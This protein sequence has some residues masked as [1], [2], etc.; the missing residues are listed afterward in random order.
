MTEGD[1]AGLSAF[2]EKYGYVGV[3]F[4]NGIKY[5]VMV[6]YDDKAG[7]E[8]EFET[9]R[10]VLDENE[11]FL[12]IDCDFS[13]AADK[14]YFYYSLNGENWTRVG[15]VL[16]MNYY[17]LHFMGYRYAIFNYATVQAGGYVDVD[18][19]RIDDKIIK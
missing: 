8:R 9:E 4:E 17:G 7:V 19:F 15:G 13:N 12:R 2:T 1:V 11:V 14:A 16:H 3:K 5:V 18:F 6:R 10:I